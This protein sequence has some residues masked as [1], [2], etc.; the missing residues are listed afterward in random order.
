LGWVEGSVGNVAPAW[1]WGRAFVLEEFDAEHG[2]C[3]CLF[4]F[5]DLSEGVVRMLEMMGVGGVKVEVF[6]LFAT[7][8]I[9]IWPWGFTYD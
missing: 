6:D 4:V 7:A 2:V 8:S 1:G 9:K 5:F 3:P